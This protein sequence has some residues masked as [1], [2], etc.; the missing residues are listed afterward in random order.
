MRASPGP[1]RNQKNNLGRT[2][3]NNNRANARPPEVRKRISTKPQNLEGPKCPWPENGSGTHRISRTR[4]LT[5]GTNTPPT[6]RTTVASPT[7][8]EILFDDKNGSPVQLHS[9]KSALS[10]TRKQP[11]L[12]Q[13]F[14]FRR[15]STTRNRENHIHIISRSGGIWHYEESR[16]D[17]TEELANFTDSKSVVQAE[18]T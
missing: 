7:R 9:D 17:W 8:N 12:R 15:L 11:K 3:T 10:R 16:H 6:N 2:I 4:P 14:L 13:N 5:K 18:V 1:H